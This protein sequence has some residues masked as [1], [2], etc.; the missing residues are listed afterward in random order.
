VRG[1]D[2]NKY[3]VTEFTQITLNVPAKLNKKSVLLKLSCEAHIVDNL[4]ANMLIGTNTLDSHKIVIDI[5]KSQ[6]IVKIC[7]NAIINL[8]IKTKANHQI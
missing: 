1:F 3:D 7:Q 2:Q 8:L 5:A 6:T 4:L